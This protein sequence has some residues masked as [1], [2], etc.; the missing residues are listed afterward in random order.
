MRELSRLPLAQRVHRTCQ[1]RLLPISKSLFVW[2]MRLVLICDSKGVPVGYDLTGPKT[3]QERERALELAAT[4]ADSTLF[5]DKGFWG[6]E[7]R[8]CMELIDIR[9]ITP[10][11][12]RPGPRP[13]SEVAKARIRLVIESVFANLKRQMRLEDHLAKTLAGLL[14]RIAQRLLALTLTMHINILTGRPPRTLAAYDGR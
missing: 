4:H 5:A 9:L 8:D 10:E 7:Y 13:A 3:G 1:L 6:K 11:R 14:Q 12:H 2:G